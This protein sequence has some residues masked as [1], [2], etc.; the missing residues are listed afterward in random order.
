MYICVC[1][2]R[3]GGGGGGGEH[4]DGDFARALYLAVVLQ[5]VL[6]VVV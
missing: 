5:G 4:L 2:E 6:V 3:G 1:G